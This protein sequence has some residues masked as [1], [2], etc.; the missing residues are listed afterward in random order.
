[1]YVSKNSFKNLVSIEPGT[2]SIDV[3]S[4]SPI[5]SHLDYSPTSPWH[6]TCKDFTMLLQKNINVIINNEDRNNL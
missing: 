6:F 1:M 5:P 4:H 3:Y 2:Y